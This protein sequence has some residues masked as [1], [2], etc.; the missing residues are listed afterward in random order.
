MFSTIGIY[1]LQ[2]LFASFFSGCGYGC[3][4]IFEIIRSVHHFLFY[5]PTYLHN[6]MI[7]AFCKVDDFSWGTKGLDK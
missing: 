6:M 2:V 7:Y 5:A 1:G 4:I 3:K